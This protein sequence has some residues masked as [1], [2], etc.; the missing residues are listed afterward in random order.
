MA[1]A[2]NDPYLGFN[3]IIEIESSALGGFSE[4]SG[5]TQDTDI[6]PYR[7]GADPQM[8][9][10]QL[11]GLRKYNN[12]MLKRGFTTSR[13]L[14]LWRLNIVNGVAD[15]RNGSIV[16]R[17]ELRKRVVEWHF[18]QGWISKYE[19][20]ALNAKGNDVAIESIEIVHEGLRIVG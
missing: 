4:A 6:V 5:L 9:V 8:N 13:T 3:F 16:L 1:I 17:D 18:E 11:M 20:P 14:W 10:R 15:R 12:I 19:G 7:E 2:R